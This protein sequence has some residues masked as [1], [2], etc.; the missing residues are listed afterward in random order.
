MKDEDERILQTVFSQTTDGRT[1]HWSSWASEANMETTAEERENPGW[2]TGLFDCFLSPMTC[3]L[4]AWCPCVLYSQNVEALTGEDPCG[5]CCGYFWLVQSL[6]FLNFFCCAGAISQCIFMPSLTLDKRKMLRDA[7]DLP[8]SCGGE[9][10][11][12]HAFCLACALCQEARELKL[13]GHS[14]I[15]PLYE[16]MTN[17]N[18]PRAVTTEAPVQVESIGIPFLPKKQQALE[19]DN[20][21]DDGSGER[22]ALL[23]YQV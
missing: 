17:N 20:N 12:V 15:N 9:S 18:T 6:G 8:D 14:P 23:K 5:S 21:G 7:Y 2:K 19:D 16:R 22:A 1:D 3:C 11:C 10:Y 13:R 4:G